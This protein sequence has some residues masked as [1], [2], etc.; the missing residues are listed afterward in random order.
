[1]RL[2]P[3]IALAILSQAGCADASSWEG[4]HH[5]QRDLVAHRGSASVVLGLDDP[6]FGPAAT[7]VALPAPTVAFPVQIGELAGGDALGRIS[8][9]GLLTNGVVILDRDSRSL[10]LYSNAGQLLDRSGRAGGGPGEFTD[11]VAVDVT[12]RGEVLVFDEGGRISTFSAEGDSLRFIGSVELDAQVYD[13]CSMHDHLYVHGARPDT[14]DA[15]L[16][17]S[18][19]GDFQFSFG[20]VYRTRSLLIHR[21]LSRGWLACVPGSDLVV[22]APR[23]LPEVHVFEPTGRLSWWSEFHGFV[24]VELIASARGT[25]VSSPSGGFHFVESLAALSDH[26]VA[27]QVASVAVRDGDQEVVQRQTFSMDLL[28]RRGTGAAGHIPR[29]AA[30]QGG[31][32][33]VIMDTIFPRVGLV[34]E[35]VLAGR[36]AP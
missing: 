7:K 18:Q 3:I 14:H 19:Q 28:H 29:I 30:A 22:F 23:L 8:D 34:D 11:P 9:V 26:D 32:L 33:A 31:R 36:R 2:D 12:A 10:S 17:Y 5:P 35:S 13:G 24:P 15:I 20:E 1:M 21:Q 25:I 6:S 16:V 4:E 27:V